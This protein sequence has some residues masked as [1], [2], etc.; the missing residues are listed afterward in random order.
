MKNVSKETIARTIILAVALINQ[1]LV[2]L[3]INPLPFAE[4]EIY[5]IISTI[6]TTAAALW[7]W[8]KNNSF[9]PAAITADECLAEIKAEGKAYTEEIGSFAEQTTFNTDDMSE[10]SDEREGV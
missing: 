9:T 2:V 7:T 3:G 10:L 6:A 5:N 1:I 4:E 8:W